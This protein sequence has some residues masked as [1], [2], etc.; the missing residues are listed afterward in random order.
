VPQVFPQQHVKLL[1]TS[2]R[3][4]WRTNACRKMDIELERNVG[5]QWLSDA[6]RAP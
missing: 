4:V 6:A 5:A 1:R 3:I 2:I